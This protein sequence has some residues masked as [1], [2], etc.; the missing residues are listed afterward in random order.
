MLPILF[1]SSDQGAPTLNNV[2]GSLISVL[3]ACL[4]T[5]FN[6]LNVSSLVVASNICTVTT[7][8]THGLVPDQRVTITG[9]ATTSL[10]GDKLIATVPTTTTF[11]FAVTQADVTESPG[12]CTLKRTS[13]GWIK[14]YTGT[15]KAIYKM[16]N[17]SSYGQMLRVDDSTAGVDARIFGVE[18]ATSVDSFTDKFP[19]EA[20]VAG[21]LYATRGAN[22]ATAKFWAIVGD[23]RFFYVITEASARFSTFPTT[24]VYGIWNFGDIISYKP[25]EAYGCTIMAPGS[26][27]ASVPDGAVT[28]GVIMGSAPSLNNQ[29]ICRGQSGLVKSVGIAPSHPGF[30]I[31]GNSGPVYPSPVDNGMV[32]SSPS[33]IVESLAY[34]G[35]PIRGIL[36]GFLTPM[37]LNS[38]LTD[39]VGGE[40]ITSTDGTNRRFIIFK[41]C[42]RSASID[43][44]AAFDLSQAWR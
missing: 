41:N 18:S 8:T 27:T 43:T 11:T 40:I 24:L 6:T 16:S 5:G 26:T 34:A 2:A 17:V 1:R 7:S 20:Q 10:N 42:S 9:A 31:V 44:C 37:V 29:R 12:S 13:L 3:D 22:N 38:S 33:F 23:D 25:G 35:N 28:Q 4:V 15:N 30:N 39:I 19:T 21:G 32:L 14:E 36:P